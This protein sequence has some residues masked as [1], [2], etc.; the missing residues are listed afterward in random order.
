ML[1]WLTLAIIAAT[2]LVIV[3][4]PSSLWRAYRTSFGARHGVNFQVSIAVLATLAFAMLVATL[5]LPERRPV[6]E[7]MNAL[8][9]A[10]GIMAGTA[11][12]YL[13]ARRRTK[14]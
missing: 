13:F 7:I 11:D 5:A 12:L 2:A 6:V 8:V 3:R 10:L 4:L 9:V 14:R 1:A